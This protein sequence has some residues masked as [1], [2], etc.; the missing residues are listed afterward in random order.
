MVFKELEEVKRMHIMRVMAVVALL[1][2]PVSANLLD[3]G[4]FEFGSLSAWIPYSTLGGAPGVHGGNYFGMTPEQGNF[5]L[6]NVA[7]FGNF[8][9][10]VYQ[11][12]LLGA[13]TYKLTGFG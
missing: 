6:A 8:D 9:G 5:F 11:Q 7:S 4:D 3:N 12:I 13:G 2:L 10:G 1:T